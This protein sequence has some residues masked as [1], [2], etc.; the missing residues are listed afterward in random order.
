LDAPLPMWAIARGMTRLGT[1]EVH[2]RVFV[3]VDVTADL[4]PGVV[5]VGDP[6]NWEFVPFNLIL[7]Y[8]EVPGHLRVPVPITPLVVD[9]NAPPLP[10]EDALERRQ[11]TA[12]DI[13]NPPALTDTSSKVKHLPVEIEEDIIRRE[14]TFE[15]NN[16][17]QSHTVSYQLS[18]AA[19]QVDV[20]KHGVPTSFLTRTFSSSEDVAVVEARWQAILHERGMLAE[21][22]SVR[23]DQVWM[24]ERNPEVLT[25]VVAA[26]R[27]AAG[28][29]TAPR[30]WAGFVASFVQSLPYH[31]PRSEQIAPNFEFWEV[32]TPLETLARG[33]GDCDTKSV[34]F[35][36]L[37]LASGG[38]RPT[39]VHVPKHMFAGAE[40]E[41]FD[42]D[43]SLTDGSVTYALVELTGNFA[44]GE[45]A[46]EYEDISGDGS[47]GEDLRTVRK[48]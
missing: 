2:S 11:I 24:V 17:G 10:E 1:A 26:L 19:V 16:D 30:A 20:G 27:V 38:P 4:A 12:A 9:P 42:S 47:L 44:L 8:F 41:P 15:D 25:E 39:L 5:V 48:P 33:W 45:V 43:V 3:P 35:A 28:D 36:A 14:W 6:L 32:M 18:L 37:L 34:L 22:N 21:G 29:K 40:V 31:I 46:S 13:L 7:K 23:G